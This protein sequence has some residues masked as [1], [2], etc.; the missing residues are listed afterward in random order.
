MVIVILLGIT[1]VMFS[2]VLFTGKP[3]VLSQA[4]TDISLHFFFWKQFAITQLKQGN[5]PL[6]NPYIFSGTHIGLFETGW[7]YPI[8]IIYLVLSLPKA[9]NWDLTLHIFLSGLFTYFWLLHRKLHP[10]SSLIGAM[11]AMFCSSRYLHIFAGH[12]DVVAA[13]T[14]TPLI[15]LAIDGVFT[16]YRVP[17]TSEINSTIHNPY[18]AINSWGWCLLGNFAVAMQVFSGHAQTLYYTAIAVG[19]YLGL[20]LIKAQN[21]FKI[22]GQVGLIYLGGIMLSAVQLFTGIQTAEESIR[23]GGMTYELGSFF[24]FHPENLITLF[25]PKFFGN[26]TTIPYWGRYFMWEMVLYIG[27][28]GLVLAIYGLLYGEKAKRRFAGVMILILFLFALGNNTYFYQFLY[29]WLPGLN[30]FRGPSKF[31]FQTSQFLILLTAI[32]FDQLIKDC[33]FLISNPSVSR[34]HFTSRIRKLG[35]GVLVTAVILI[36]ASIL[37]YWGATSETPNWWNN[38][39]TSIAHTQQSYLPT[40]AYQ[41]HKFIEYIGNYAGNMLIIAAVILCVFAL[42]VLFIKP[43]G[44][45]IMLIGLLTI[46][47]IVVF[48]YSSQP[49]F[50]LS[51]LKYSGLDSIKPLIAT[52]NRILNIPK[53]NADMV[54]GLYDIWGNQPLILRRYAEY[55]AYTQGGALD[56]LSP[57]MKFTNFGALYLLR[58]QYILLTAEKPIEYLELKPEKILPRTLLIQKYRILKTRDEILAAISH[59]EFNPKEEAIVEQQPLWMNSKSQYPNSNLQSTTFTS[60]RIKDISTDKLELEVEITNPAILVITDSYSKGWKAVALSGSSQDEYQIMPVDYILRGIPLNTGHHRFQL[61]YLPIGFLVGKWIS[62]VSGIIYLIL[63]FSLGYCI[64]KAF[65]PNQPYT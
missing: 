28:V 22:M 44:L 45:K 14:W 1:I 33:G 62:I 49:T 36:I 11:L 37:V 10:L 27:I 12:L 31:I 51:T 58:C 63:I 40:A 18:S 29:H 47:E 25:A 7:L 53:S 19:I 20:N 41:D 57:Q 46:G 8:N 34:S 26:E 55:I 3:I 30:R 50:D 21:K 24:S 39:I 48:A 35:I 2:D 60:I 43:A 56:R 42:I 52:D 64:F 4:N 16:Y 23:S 6:W 17:N 59:P 15:F 65:H 54:S 38:W 5:Y 9:I 13:M 32:G 61:V